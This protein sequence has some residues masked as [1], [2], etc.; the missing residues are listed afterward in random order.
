[1]TT[2][3]PLVAKNALSSVNL[4]ALARLEARY[5]QRRSE[6]RA[7]ASARDYYHGQQ[8][9]HL[10]ERQRQ[11]LGLRGKPTFCANYCRLV[12]DAVAERLTVIGFEA[13][14]AEVKAWLGM[15][16]NAA[17]LDST[18][19]ALHLAAIRDGEAYLLLD[20]DPQADR[21]RFHLHLADDGSGG[22]SLGYDDA[23]QVAYA[24]KRW[25]SEGPN[26]SSQRRLTLYYP[27]RIEK[28]L[29]HSSAPYWQPYQ[30]PSD[31]FPTP[32]VD[33]FGEP[34]GLPIIPFINREGSS[35]LT[36]VMP[37]QDA[38]N[39]T[40][41]DLIAVA[42][43]NAFPLLVAQGFEIPADFL[44]GPG[45]LIQI[46]PSLDGHSDFR[47]LPGANLENFIALLQSLVVEV[48]RVSSTPLSRLQ[49]SGQVAAEGT[50]KQQEAGLISKVE[51]KQVV[52]GN[53]WEDAMRLALRLQQTF[54]A[55][56]GPD[57]NTPLS[58]LW[59]P[60]APRSELAHLQALLLKAQLGVP[61]ATL[62]AEAGYAG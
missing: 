14:N 42:D 39:K 34:L 27:D 60:A 30:T 45:S 48:A 2:L 20:F 25:W 6:Q 29:S 4:E 18:S 44:I 49:A 1:M 55:V 22:I 10:T 37:L 9:T 35:E 11:F 5:Q 54:G 12:V 53:A 50:L 3:S 43:T 62:L 21:P 41:L 46:P 16:W 38:L 28:Y 59:S 8:P 24:A 33:S 56:P 13:P 61:S 19:Q 17:R 26:G 23:G 52:F 57:S 58:T 32:W 36:D 47:M 31:P 7:I 15:L 51:R 40:L